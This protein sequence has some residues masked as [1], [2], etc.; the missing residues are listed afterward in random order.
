MLFIFSS[1]VPQSSL[2]V[3]RIH[4]ADVNFELDRVPLE[5]LVFLLV[6]GPG[7][8]GNWGYL[9]RAFLQAWAS[10]PGQV[11][12]P[13]LWNSTELL[14]WLNL[15]VTNNKYVLRYRSHL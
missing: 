4:L 5:A 15:V 7:S 1:L 9:L 13:A 6:L 12:V 3:V 8:I 14:T 2:L 11:P 10:K